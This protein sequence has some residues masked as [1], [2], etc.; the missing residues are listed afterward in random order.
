M[1]FTSLFTPELCFANAEGASKKRVIELLAQNIAEVSKSLD[2]TTLFRHL[3]SREKLG[4]TG[5]GNGLAIPHCRC[6]DTNESIFACMTLSS[7]VDFDTFDQ[8][9]VDIIFALVVPQNEEDTHL[10]HLAELAGA[11]Q[12]TNFLNTLRAAA[13]SEELYSALQQR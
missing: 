5:I 8:Q 13:N 1:E 6:S 10:K 4:S 3:I 12:D 11:G 2:P 7:A 9:P